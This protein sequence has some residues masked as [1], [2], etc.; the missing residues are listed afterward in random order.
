MEK[1]LYIWLYIP[2]HNFCSASY[3]AGS[4]AIILASIQQFV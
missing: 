1:S 2:D 3:N 4:M